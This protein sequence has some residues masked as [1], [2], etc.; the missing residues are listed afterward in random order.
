MRP[1]RPVSAEEATPRTVGPGKGRGW[2]PALLGRGQARP[3]GGLGSHPTRSGSWRSSAPRCLR[4]SALKSQL[5]RPT[6]PP[7]RAGVPGARLRPLAAQA[8]SGVPCRG[9]G[10][11]RP[12][13]R[14]FWLLAAAHR[15]RG[16][17]PRTSARTGCGGRRGP[18]AGSAHSRLPAQGA[19]S[20]RCSR[21]EA[22]CLPPNFLLAL[23]LVSHPR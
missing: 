13:A 7:S 3:R 21:L 17:A 11:G 22:T 5:P 2:T 23:V 14:P 9:W 4:D 19:F 20:S 1:R 18:R 15:G 12:G 8:E 10:P 16:R 6:Q